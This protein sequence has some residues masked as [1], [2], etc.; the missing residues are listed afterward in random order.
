MSAL[1]DYI[2][3]PTFTPVFDASNRWAATRVNLAPAT[4]PDAGLL[5]FLFPAAP[6]T[7]DAAV[8]QLPL[9]IEAD[10]PQHWV[11]ML[12]SLTRA[13]SSSHIHLLFPAVCYADAE[14]HSALA[15][16][17]SRG[18]ILL[19]R[20]IPAEALPVQAIG[21]D[22]AQGLNGHDTAL[23]Q[24]YKGP[25]LAIGVGSPAVYRACQQAGFRWFE[26]DWAL[27]PEIDQAPQATTSR[28][29][30]M[31]LLGLVAGDA[32]SHEIE[33]L[34]KCDPNLSYQLLKLVNSVSFSLTHK[35]SSFNQ[36][37]TLLGRRQLQRW[38]QLLLYAGHYADSTACAL[39]GLVAHRAA[40]M[41]ALATVR[42]GSQ[43]DRDRAFMVGLFSLLDVLFKAP[44]IDLVTPLNLEDEVT[45]ALIA[46]EGTLGCLLDLA[47]AAEAAPGEIFAQTLT[48][49]AIAPD[50]FMRAQHG[51]IAW[52]AQICREI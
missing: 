1:D 44:I 8:V 41:E 20:G 45:R 36:A 43:G 16:L 24:K 15:D 46:H 26:G 48:K 29:T 39:L 25:H 31:N 21:I 35:I 10:N 17:D 7:D 3:P 30:L 5:A 19:A 22:V 47:I 50:V 40:L 14:A 52:A 51:A 34:L 38:L 27:H 23:L 12:E 42:G 2:L 18:I 32:A 6:E 49:L 4:L 33:T 11:Q 28:S 37:I 9:L 13:S